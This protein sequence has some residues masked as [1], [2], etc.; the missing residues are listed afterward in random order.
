MT[1]LQ[2]CP[3][4]TAPS[5]S[6]QAASGLCARGHAA[7]DMVS[8]LSVEQVADKHFLVVEVSALLIWNVTFHSDQRLLKVS[9]Y[10]GTNS[11]VSECRLVLE[12]LYSLQVL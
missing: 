12:R 6:K 8:M 11:P 5:H 9:E 1:E 3:H 10:V 4:S 7:A 2:F